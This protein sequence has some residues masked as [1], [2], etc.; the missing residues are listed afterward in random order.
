MFAFLSL[1]TLVE[2]SYEVVYEKSN[3]TEP[4]QFL[5]CEDLGVLH[6]N[7]TEIDLEKLRDYLDNHHESNPSKFE[8]VN[9][10]KSGGYLIL[11]GMVCLIAKD[12]TQLRNIIGFFHSSTKMTFAVKR[13]T[14]DLVKM[15]H[16]NDAIEQLTVLKKEH[17]YS[18]CNKS[19]ARFHMG[20]EFEL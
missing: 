3:K 14:F 11:N 20:L 12:R 5:V 4:V 2:E 17:S 13:D 19:N 16:R 15:S 1:N 8:E 18:N 10:I 7:K 9:R 6:P